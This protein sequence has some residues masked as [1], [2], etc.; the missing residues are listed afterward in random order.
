MKLSVIIPARNA[1]MH[2]RYLLSA[3]LPQL[4]PDD[5]CFVVDD[6]SSDDT[7]RIAR[8]HA[9]PVLRIETRGG[10]AAA[11]NLGA[12]HATGD[13]LVFLDADVVP[14]PGLLGRMREQLRQAP[15]LSAL[16][17]SY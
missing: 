14:Y 16:I 11:R 12:S 17:G 6:A 4:L 3:L 1:A 9:V 13:I 10:P 15:G 2:L 5:E 8:D 7:A